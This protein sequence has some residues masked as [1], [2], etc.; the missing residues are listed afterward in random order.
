MSYTY[1]IA[2]TWEIKLVEFFEI[3][4]LLA[5]LS[6]LCLIYLLYEHIFVETSNNKPI[7]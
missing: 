5:M 3:E 1:P 6:S 7:F 4:K 2:P